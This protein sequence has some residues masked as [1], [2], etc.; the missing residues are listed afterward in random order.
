MEVNSR[1][2]V[3]GLVGS[4]HQAVGIDIIDHINQVKFTDHDCASMDQQPTLIP[5]TNLLNT[6]ARLPSRH[7]AAGGFK[8]LDSAWFLRNTCPQTTPHPHVGRTHTYTTGLKQMKIHEFNT[9]NFA[10]RTSSVSCFLNC[11]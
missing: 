9:L 11:I 6:M 8:M 4:L 10:V 3:F 5:W 7:T 1:V 2:F